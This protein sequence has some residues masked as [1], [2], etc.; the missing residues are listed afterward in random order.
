[1]LH[2]AKFKIVFKYFEKRI[3][4]NI[5]RTEK[6]AFTSTVKRFLKEIQWKHVYCVFL[7]SHIPL[8]EWIY[9]LVWT[10]MKSLLETDMTPAD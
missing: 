5:I 6:F 8:L 9:N 4:A 7:S 3:K 10:L 2:F 1:M